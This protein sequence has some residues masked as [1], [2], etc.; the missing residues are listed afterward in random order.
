MDGTL[1]ERMER[2]EKEVE[3]IK[4]EIA[5]PMPRKDWRA[6]CGTAKGDP[7]FDEMIRLGQEYRKRQREDYDE[8]PD[9]GP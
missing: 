3:R 4:S 1:A 7:G 9:A 2:L 6:W 5:N 8:E